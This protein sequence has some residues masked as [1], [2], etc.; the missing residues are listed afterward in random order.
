MRRRIILAG[1][2]GAAAL[3]MVAG[4]AMAHECFVIG[5]TEHSQA[6][7]SGVW[8]KS[9][10]ADFLVGEFGVDPACAAAAQA[11]VGQQGLVTSLLINQTKTLGEESNNPNLANGKGL[12]HAQESPYAGAIVGTALGFIGANSEPGQV[13]AA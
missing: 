10:V 9:S 3:T 1:A 2:A 6:Q 4:P 12:E 11:Y 13:C 8:A 5:M 7:N